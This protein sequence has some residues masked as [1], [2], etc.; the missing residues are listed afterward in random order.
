[1]NPR[2]FIKVEGGITTAY[3]LREFARDGWPQARVYLDALRKGYTHGLPENPQQSPFTGKWA[4]V[5]FPKP[6]P[7]S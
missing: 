6:P 1:M 7:R 4:T 5:R 3:A 2:G